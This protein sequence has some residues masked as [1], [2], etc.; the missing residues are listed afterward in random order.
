MLRKRFMKA[1]RELYDIVDQTQTDNII[2]AAELIVD[3]VKKGAHVHIFDTGH[4][5]N[6]ELTNRAGGLALLKP[7][8]YSF[9]VDDPVRVTDRNNISGN[10]EGLGKFILDHSK[11]VTGDVMILGSVSGKSA[12][13]IDLALA[14]REMGLKTIVITS[15]EYSSSVPSAH[16][17]G[18]HLFDLGDVVID[19]C[20]PKGD[21]ML[22]VD[23]ATNKF[24]PASG[25]SAAYIMWCVCADVVEMLL[26]QGYDPT[27]FKSIN[28]PDGK[29]NYDLMCKKYA[30]TGI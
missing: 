16:S 21:A 1:V 20:A 28:Y 25:L 5:I 10:F 9:S 7:F 17:S 6:S 4:I 2:K 3:C 14:A 30:E 29:E 11:A 22:E 15:L 27:I 12:N 26:E 24:G 18:K 8:K 23:G 13:V 19:N